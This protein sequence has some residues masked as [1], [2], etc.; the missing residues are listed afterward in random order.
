[1]LE[2]NRF[3]IVMSRDQ[4]IV[5]KELLEWEVGCPAVVVSISENVFTLGL[6]SACEGYDVACGDT[7]PNIAETRPARDAMEVRENPH[8]WKLLKLIVGKADFVL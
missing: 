7:F 8:A 3:S 6:E 4:G 5:G 2:A 1:M